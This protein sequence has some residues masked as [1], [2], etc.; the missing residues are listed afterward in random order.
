MITRRWPGLAVLG[1]LLVVI[2]L[3]VAPGAPAHA[4]PG[5]PEVVE[6]EY[7]PLGSADRDLLVRVRLAGLW[8]IPAG[9]LARERGTT[10]QIREI[11]QFIAEE[12]ADLDEQVQQVAD[13]LGVA[14]PDQPHADH[15]VFL[16]RLQDR[17]GEEFDLEFI[18]LLREAHGQIYP[19]IAY[20]RAGTRNDLIREFADTGEEFV[21]RHM[22]YLES[23]G[24]VDWLHI[25]PPPEPAGA[26]SRFLAAAP[27][28]V[29]PVVIW[30]LL[31]AAAIAGTVTVIRTVRPR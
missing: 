30:M 1:P 17:T 2:G 3:L 16:N 13:A 31:A 22:A 19:L 24:L 28:G 5:D 11:G 12:H 18:Q 15:Q 29:S 14:L 7:G 10:E 23:S 20:V 21:G 25:P 6:T 9:E 26:P 8:E 27:A 4:Q